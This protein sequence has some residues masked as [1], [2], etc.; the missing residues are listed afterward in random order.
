MVQSLTT[1]LQNVL[2]WGDVNCMTLNISKKCTCHLNINNTL[3][4]QQWNTRIKI[5]L[6]LQNRILFY[7]SYILPHLDYW[8]II[9]GSFN[10]V[11]EDKLSKFQ[12]RAARIILNKDYNTPSTELFTYL[13]STTFHERVLYQKTIA[14]YKI[15]NNICPDYLNNH[16]AYTSEFVFCLSIDT[17]LKI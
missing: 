5:Y 11:S 10:S 1:D 6:S 15:V 17:H 9:W 4:W 16:I 7:N 8:C 3:F 12:K 14:M 13:N 2:S